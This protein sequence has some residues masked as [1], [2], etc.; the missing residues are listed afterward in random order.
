MPAISIQSISF[1]HEALINWMIANPERKLR[2]CAA[3]FGYTQ[4]WLSCIIHSDIFQA[5]LAERQNEVF[6]LVAQDI[7]DKLRGCAD[8]ALEKLAIKLE[9]TEDAKYVLDAADKLLSKMGYGP[10]TARNPA[11]S[12]TLT[13][14]NTFIIGSGDLAAARQLQRD[15]AQRLSLEETTELG[16]QAGEQSKSEVTVEFL[17]AR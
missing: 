14:N 13:Q 6:T 8:I 16:P 4:A 2:D 5:K 11:P 7:P 15:F 3:Y 10:A 17:P 1:T 12:A 9:E